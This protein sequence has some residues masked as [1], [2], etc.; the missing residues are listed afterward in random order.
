MLDK[1][2]TW[3][4]HM[5]TSVTTKILIKIYLLP[6]SFPVFLTVSQQKFL[7]IKGLTLSQVLSQAPGMSKVLKLSSPVFSLSSQGLTPS[8]IHSDSKHVYLFERLM[9]QMIVLIFLIS[10]RFE[11]FCEFL[12]NF[13]N[14]SLLVDLKTQNTVL[15]SNLAV[16]F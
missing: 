4:E 12:L 6:C 1:V 3:G 11:Y 10:Q 8:C 16:V 7:D 13:Q 2:S 5:H 14:G 9:Q 15:Q